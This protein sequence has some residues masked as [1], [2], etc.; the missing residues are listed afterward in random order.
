[1]ET[2]TKQLIDSGLTQN[3]AIIYELLI[4]SGGLRA[5]VIVRR[6]GNILSR[7]LVYAILN[8]LT[9]LGLVEKDETS[10]KI[11]KFIPAHPSKLQD[12]AAARRAAAEVTLEA[13][14]AV[15][16]RIISD[17]NLVSNKPGVRFFE[18]QAGVEKVLFE[19]LKNTSETI[20]AYT[21]TD[22][23]TQY[24]KDINERYIKERLRLGVKKKILMVD[25]PTARRKVAESGEL[26]DIRLINSE[27]T[28]TAHAVI[29]IHNNR[30]TYITFANDTMTATVIDDPAIYRLHR[31]LFESHWETAK[32]P[33]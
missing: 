3:Q 10:S 16:P 24:V 15:I 13:A 2:Y 19:T 4:K 21:D 5:S 6:L 23:V 8:E 14:S 17:Y 1:M 9:T 29:E 11:T 20:Y 26:T 27:N 12:I 33:E 31:F 22:A 28:P 25:S 32:R 7:P 30:V 18:G